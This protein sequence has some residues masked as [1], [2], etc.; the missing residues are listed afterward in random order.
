MVHGTEIGK[1]PYKFREFFSCWLLG[2]SRCFLFV[3]SFYSILLACSADIKSRYLG[4]GSA[5][6]INFSLPALASI[7][8]ITCFGYSVSRVRKSGVP[9]NPLQSTKQIEIADV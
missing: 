2:F 5:D 9:F 8:L 1:T 7:I 6:L 4:V 3:F